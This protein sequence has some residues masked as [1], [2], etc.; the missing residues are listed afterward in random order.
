MN[1]VTINSITTVSGCAGSFTGE[2]TAEVVLLVKGS[3]SSV[4]DIRRHIEQAVIKPVVAKRGERNWDAALTIGAA[5]QGEIERGDIVRAYDFP[6]SRD[7]VYVEG[8]V[9]TREQDRVLIHVTTEMWEGEPEQVNRFEVWSPLGV[10][11]L[12]GAP[13]VFLIAKREVRS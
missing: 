7:D 1:N 6:G 2:P 12:M 5:K 4:E 10:S 9:K 11:S 3:A 13:C 8:V